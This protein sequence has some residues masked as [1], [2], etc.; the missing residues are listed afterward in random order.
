MKYAI[1]IADGAADFP[2][3]ELNG[4]TPLEAARTPNLDRLARGGAGWGGRVGVALTTP[5]GFG[6]GSDVCSMSLLGYDPAR[7]HTGRA[8]LEA[9][10]MGLR[11]GP[12][13]WIFRLNFV[14]TSEG[15]DEARSGRMLD[16][17]AG[18]ISDGEAKELAAALMEAWA[19][20]APEL[21]RG[22]TLTHGVSYRCILIDASGRDYNEVTTTP[23]H[24]IPGEPWAFHVPVGS[25]ASGGRGGPAAAHLAQLMEL[26]RGALGGHP[27]NVARVRAG[28]RPA[29]MA[30]IWG[31]GLRPSM[32]SFYERFG[33]RGAMITAV[34]LLAGIASL[35]GWERLSVPGVTSYHD[36]DYAVQG[37][38]TCA[39]LDRFDIVCCHVESPDEAS[40]QGDW[41]TKVA[42]IE[43]I[44]AHVVGPVMEHMQR[45]GD[46][47]REE[48]AEGWRM[49]VM[50][51][52]Y[53]LVSTKKHDATPPPL[54]M[55]GAW[56]RSAV[57]RLFTEAHA[58]ESDL[59]VDPGHEL[60][61]YFLFGGLARV[62]NTVRAGG[63]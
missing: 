53:T 40:H 43:A 1:I 52:H 63:G 44:D 10:A 41:K 56:V 29:N 21:A 59:S 20:H 17:S 30:W 9:A 57:E 61:E 31:Q 15:G 58:N 26:S 48:R 62:G 2:L 46:P 45:Y 47:A 54:V 16:H 4:Q 25:G 60:M 33:L 7:Y 27:V 13:D 37:R 12:N 36:T 3:P 32:P 28:K 5:P 19:A 51:D 35:I 42:A 6:A 22:L 14:T 55:A 50:P 18:A 49:L 23:P 39:A 38:A 34:D 11:P 8:P 24:E